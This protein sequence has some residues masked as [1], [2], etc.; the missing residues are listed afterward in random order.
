MSEAAVLA[1]AVLLGALVE[2][3]ASVESPNADGQTALMI[4]ARTSR[5][6][7]ARVLLQHGANVNAVENGAARRR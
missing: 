7:A 4:V 1:D 5:V 2:G 3:G 6:D